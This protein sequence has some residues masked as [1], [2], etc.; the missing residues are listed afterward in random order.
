MRLLRV[1][2]TLPA[3][4]LLLVIGVQ[5]ASA[6]QLAVVSPRL[7]TEA[8]ISEQGD[9]LVYSPS[10]G[11]TTIMDVATGATHD[12]QTPGC[13]AI[14]VAGVG[15]LLHCPQPALLA[16]DGEIRQFPVGNP[17][18]WQDGWKWGD[19]FSELGE[20]WAAGIRQVGPGPVYSEQQ[21]YLNLQTARVEA[22]DRIRDLDQLSVAAGNA[23]PC[24]DYH[25]PR[26]FSLIFRHSQLRILN[27]ARHTSTRL[28]RCGR[29]CRGGG[30]PAHGRVAWFTQ[31]DRRLHVRRVRGKPDTCSWAIP[32]MGGTI[33][34]QV[35]LAKHQLFVDVDFAEGGRAT[36]LY[37][38][39][40]RRC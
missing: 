22:D 35:L 33:A 10:T 11:V 29:G 5:P 36:A 13:D 1:H 17:P 25:G 6:G 12:F 8:Y 39:S 26:A 9:R 28:T 15:A 20:F 27:C 2:L 37:R 14:A 40:L 16:A 31:G 23:S 34:P 3:F 4:I 21:I 32:R 24:R 18:Y 30:E 19:Q 38:A 7:A